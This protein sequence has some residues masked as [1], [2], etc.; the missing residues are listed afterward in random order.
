MTRVAEPRVM[1][2]R[3]LLLAALALLTA[4]CAGAPPRPARPAPAPP[5]EAP[6]TPE[7][8]RAALWAEAR[9]H[10]GLVGHPWDGASGRARLDQLAAALLEQDSL[11][12]TLATP[13]VFDLLSQA[14]DRYLL[15][16]FPTAIDVSAGVVVS[17][18]LF[19]LVGEVVTSQRLRVSRRDIPAL[20][21]AERTPLGP[22]LRVDAINEGRQYY[23]LVDDRLLLVRYEDHGER[24]LRNCY[25]APSWTLGASTAPDLDGLIAAL[26]GDDPR[27]QLAALTYLGG[28]HFDPQ[29]TLPSWTHEDLGAARVVAW[30]RES[31]EVRGLVQRLQGDR[32]PWVR[33]AAAF[34]EASWGWSGRAR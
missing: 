15:V 19:D 10:L 33:E 9:T 16:E 23:A 3:P 5:A 26:E 20:S 8:D 24:L 11:E 27:L 4:S 7:P 21:L 34:V 32:H 6:P 30:A 31:S 13:C 25:Q 1:S 18:H 22:L 28:E 2:A 14:P 17:A 29:G 12:D